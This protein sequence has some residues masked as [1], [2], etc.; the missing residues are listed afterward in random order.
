MRDGGLTGILACN[1]ASISATSF[2]LMP[3]CL[4]IHW[5]TIAF[6]SFARHIFASAWDLMRV[7]WLD[8]LSRY[9]WIAGAGASQSSCAVPRAVPRCWTT[10]G[11]GIA[12]VLTN[13]SRSRPRMRLNRLSRARPSLL[14]PFRLRVTMKISPKLGFRSQH[15]CNTFESLKV[16]TSLQME[17]LHMYHSNPSFIILHWD[18]SGFVSSRVLRPAFSRTAFTSPAFQ[19]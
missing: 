11:S 16:A 17:E 18:P 9:M 14:H 10:P 5:T 8:R 19:T 7:D 1:H 15:Y 2:P 12:A 13:Q 4:G 3:S 6:P